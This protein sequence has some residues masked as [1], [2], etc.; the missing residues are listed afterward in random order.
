MIILAEIFDIGAWQPKTRLGIKV[1]NKE[2][3][4]IEEI[5]AKYKAVVIIGDRNGHVGV[6][7]GKDQETT[8]AIAEAIRTAKKNVIPIYLGCGSWECNCGT[9]H[10]LPYSLYGKSG[11]VEVKLIPA[12][13]GVGIAAGETIKLVL[14]LAGVKDVWSFSRGHTKNKYNTAHATYLALRQL[15]RMKNVEVSNANVL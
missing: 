15:L 8:A 11:S 12:P 3:T 13:R 1:K 10:S 5:L 4:S 7:I 2:I 14:E 9:K 6:G